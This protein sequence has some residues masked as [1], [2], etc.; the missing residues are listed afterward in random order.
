LL[1]YQQALQLFQRLTDLD[2]HLG[3]NLTD[4]LVGSRIHDAHH[5]SS[6]VV[7][8]GKAQSLTAVL[9]LAVDGVHRFFQT[10]GIHRRTALRR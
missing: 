10:C 4:G 9:Q 2:R 3:R 1:A 7:I 6:A 8:D 5:Y